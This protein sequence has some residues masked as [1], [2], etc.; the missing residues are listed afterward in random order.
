MQG[1]SYKQTG[2]VA[3]E[4]NFLILLSEALSRV[5]IFSGVAAPAPSRTAASTESQSNSVTA[6]FLGTCT[7]G[8]HGGERRADGH[9]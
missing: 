8:R 6:A 4:N 9:C 7:E 3:D 1:G 5:L 2:G